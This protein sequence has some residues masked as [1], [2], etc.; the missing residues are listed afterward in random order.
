MTKWK[1]I[2]RRAKSRIYGEGIEGRIG[3]FQILQRLGRQLQKYNW[4]ADMR[5]YTDDE[6][7]EFDTE[8]GDSF[9]LRVEKT[10]D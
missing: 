5:F 7:I 6:C 10:N 1:R 2:N 4:V 9:I 8:D 3:S